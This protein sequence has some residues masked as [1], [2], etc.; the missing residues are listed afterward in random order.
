M[1]PAESIVVSPH[2]QLAPRRPLGEILIEEGWATAGDVA[3]A[4]AD[5]ADLGL[6]LASLLISRGLL[7]PDQAARALGRQHAIPAALV[8]H[9]DARDLEVA[10]SLPADVAHGYSALALAIARDGSVV[11]CVR[12]PDRAE[13]RA[14]LEHVL[15][16]PV[17]LVVA[18]SHALIPRL[19]EVYG[20]PPDDFEI[21]MSFG[22]PT[23]PATA[24]DF[25]AFSAG[26]LTLASL[27]DVGVARG[28]DL[29]QP[30]WL[31]RTAA[32][33]ATAASAPPT[34]SAA[35]AAAGSVPT[36]APAIARTQTPPAIARTQTPPTS[37]SALAALSGRQTPPAGMP[38]L[39]GT[40]TAQAATLP[41]DRDTLPEGMRALSANRTP[42]IGTPALPAPA[43]APAP[44][45]PAPPLPRAS[46]PLPSIV[47]GASGKQTAPA[48]S[49]S[50]PSSIPPPSSPSP[51]A[52]PA[53]LVTAAMSAMA[54]AQ[55]RDAVIDAAFTALS[56]AWTAAVLFSVKDS[57]ALGQRGFGGLL[58]SHT[59]ATLVIPLQ[60]PSFLR[61][62]WQ[63]RELCESGSSSGASSPVQ[64][65]LLRLLGGGRAFCT[66]VEIAG[67]VI[68]LLA[69]ASPTDERAPSALLALAHAL[70]EH[71][72]RIIRSAKTA[73]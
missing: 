60:S 20:P 30:T 22:E 70:G 9:L 72:G 47:S 41:P 13:L 37:T 12:D 39:S 53:Q 50:A 62:A 5:Q 51:S 66:P 17:T 55:A 64:D 44:P 2:R 48:P 33:V 56:P 42:P 18:S 29:D 3:Q 32:A 54:Q 10:R 27:D 67:R 31:P 71:L 63:S 16:R 1:E 52:S 43:P 7:D 26:A 6:R 23:L 68:G 57:A 59:V 45:A 65:R 38:A 11:V 73:S 61:N 8:R 36:F 35:T 4:L 46:S 69:A 28:Q 19:R 49:S 24:A 21:D 15:R 14:A 34:W 58:T 40:Q 25:D